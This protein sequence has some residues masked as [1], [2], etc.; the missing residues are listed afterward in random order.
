M[1]VLC[2]NLACMVP[3]QNLDD[4]DLSSALVSMLMSSFITNYFFFSKEVQSNTGVRLFS[5]IVLCYS[6]QAC[7]LLYILVKL[8]VTFTC[9]SLPCEPL[10][11]F[12]RMWLWFWI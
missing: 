7:G 1:P 5:G 9:T 2:S 10:H 11:L 3:K 12:F 8:K 4:T 6:H